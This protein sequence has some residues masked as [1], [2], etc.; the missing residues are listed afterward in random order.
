[1]SWSS[2]PELL[3]WAG[4][5]F[6]NLQDPQVLSTKS[7]Y[8]ILSSVVKVAGKYATSHRNLLEVSYYHILCTRNASCLLHAQFSL[9]TEQPNTTGSLVKAR[10]DKQTYIHMAICLLCRKPLGETSLVARLIVW[11]KVAMGGL[12]IF[13]IGELWRLKKSSRFHGCGYE[14]G[15]FSCH[16]IRK[17]HSSRAIER[18]EIHKTEKKGL[19]IEEKKA[20]ISSRVSSQR[21]CLLFG[22]GVNTHAE[23]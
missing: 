13:A 9:T 16:S 8:M 18:A 20:S 1:M 21:L 15:A 5:A 17:F 4:H 22:A 6:R 3:G 23:L 14:A 2:V 12:R 19:F 11:S 10:T 7:C